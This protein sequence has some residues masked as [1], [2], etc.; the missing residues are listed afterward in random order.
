MELTVISTALSAFAASC[1][2]LSAVAMWRIQ[3]RNQ[4]ESARPELVVLGWK[5]QKY[6]DRLNGDSSILFSSIRNVGRGYA[7]NV[8]INGK[9]HS[10]DADWLG[11]PLGSTNSTEEVSLIPPGESHEIAGDLNFVWFPVDEREKRGTISLVLDYWDTLGLHYETTYT[12]YTFPEE[13]PYSGQVVAP[14]V[15]LTSRTT[16][17]KTP[18]HLTLKARIGTAKIRMK[19]RVQLSIQKIK[20]LLRSKRRREPSTPRTSTSLR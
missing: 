3:R 11:A 16:E 14:G 5:F 18:E 12:F 13:V 17:R 15:A 20:K 4:M 1:S 9:P 19:Q 6:P 10:L 2:A 8:N 7:L